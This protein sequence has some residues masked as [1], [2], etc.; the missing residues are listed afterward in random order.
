MGSVDQAWA[1]M[2]NCGLITLDSYEA[3]KYVESVSLEDAANKKLAWSIESGTGRATIDDE[4]VVTGILDAT[5]TVT[6]VASDGS[7]SEDMCT[8]TISNQIVSFPEVNV[9]KNWV[10]DEVNEDGTATLWGGWI[11]EAEKTS[12]C[13]MVLPP[14]ILIRPILLLLMIPCNGDISSSRKAC[15]PC[16]M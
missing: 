5:V 9:I 1:N 10:F 2:D 11:D 14:C 15:M 12:R 3:G 6:A 8:V 4:G 16:P 13:L 7:Y